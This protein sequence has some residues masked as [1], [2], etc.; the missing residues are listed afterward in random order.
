MR[1][2]LDLAAA[3]VGT[4]RRVI[5]LGC[6]DGALLEHLITRQGCAGHGV[7]ADA[8]GFHACVR[9]GVPVTQGDLELELAELDDD[10]FDWA[11]LSLTLQAVR[12]PADVLASM[13]RVAPR[14]VVSLPNFGHWRLRLA[15]AG[16][17]RMPRSPLLPDPWYASPNIH[18]C[19]LRDFEHLAADAGLRITRRIALDEHGHPAARGGRPAPNLLAAAAVYALARA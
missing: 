5:D 2:D 13:R 12:H 17:G 10:A 16:R 3:L 19:T 11:V 6:G 15:F 8:E 9:R 1:P 14:C 18:L 7:E 4:G